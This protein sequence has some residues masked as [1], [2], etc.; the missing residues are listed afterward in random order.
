MSN[1]VKG[2][3]LTQGLLTPTAAIDAEYMNGNQPWASADEYLNYKDS[4]FAT[5]FKNKTILV[6]QSDNSNAEMWNPNNERT[7]I[8]KQNNLTLDMVNYL[9]SKLAYTYNFTY[10]IAASP[11]I[12][13]LPSQIPISITFTATFVASKTNDT[14]SKTLTVT[15]VSSNTT[16]WIKNGI[17]YVKT[18]TIDPTKSSQNSDVI[19]AIVTNSEGVS[20]TA[21]GSSKTVTFSKPWFIFE[22]NTESLNDP[23]QVIKEL[24]NKTKPNLKSDTKAF[25]EEIT[26]NMSKDYLYFAIPNTRTLVTVDQ[27]AGLSML[28]SKTAKYLPND[29][30]LGTYSI[31]R[32]VGALLAGNITFNLKIS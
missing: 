25:N 5:I 9:N 4:R 10:N 16:N 8:L 17:T 19:S 18:I 2:L 26:V 20:G 28:E 13:T 22:E 31:Y 30:G 23:N 27:I 11:S 24:L 7:F 6:K 21:I 29:T 12:V 14:G 3:S 15:D 1:N 32:W